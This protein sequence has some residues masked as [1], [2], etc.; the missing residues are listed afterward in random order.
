MIAFR[1]FLA[2][3]QLLPDGDPVATRSSRL[4]PVRCPDGMLAMLKIAVEEEEAR[5]AAL[6]AWW[7]GDGAA[8][9]LARDGEALLLERGRWI[10]ARRDGSPGTG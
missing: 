9:V 1:R 8:H 10:L 5:G 3:W 6:M 2:L 4:L 7:A